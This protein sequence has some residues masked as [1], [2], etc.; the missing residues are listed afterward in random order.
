MLTTS[1][2]DIFARVLSEMLFFYTTLFVNNIIML[3]AYTIKI[4]AY[5]VK[6]FQH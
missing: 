3:H 1:K 2:S 4:G 6:H 5:A